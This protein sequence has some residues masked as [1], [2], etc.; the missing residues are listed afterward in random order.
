MTD[1]PVPA[2][3]GVAAVVAIIGLIWWYGKA[4]AINKVRTLWRESRKSD[5]AKKNDVPDFAKGERIGK[6][7]SL[8]KATDRVMRKGGYR[9]PY[10]K[11]PGSTYSKVR[12][13]LSS[14][15]RA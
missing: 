3:I 7:E 6:G 11:G 5:K 1:S 9:P 10:K 2:I 13:H 8:D 14:R 15:G 4:W 12:K